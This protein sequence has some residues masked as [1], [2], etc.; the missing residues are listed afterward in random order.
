MNCTV[1]E[2]LKNAA[3]KEEKVSWKYYRLRFNLIY[4]VQWPILRQWDRIFCDV[5]YVDPVVKF[6]WTLFYSAWFSPYHIAYYLFF[7]VVSV[8]CWHNNANNKPL[9]SY[10]YHS[11][12]T[13]SWT[14]I[15]HAP[16]SVPGAKEASKLH[17]L[18]RLEPLSA[19][20]VSC[21]Y[22]Q[23]IPTWWSG[24]CEHPLC[25]LHV[26]G[27]KLTFFGKPSPFAGGWQQVLRCF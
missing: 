6:I 14:I 20:L 12:V 23:K 5:I 10:S 16:S 19:L 18:N 15:H 4:K 21:H 3:E 11:Q 22:D 9:E 17:F 25:F 24:V 27:S 1:C 8:T 13:G 7:V 2:Y 26:P